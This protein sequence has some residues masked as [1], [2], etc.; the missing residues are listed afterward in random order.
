MRFGRD[1]L[2]LWP[3]DPDVTYLNHG[4][5]GVVPRRVLAAQQALRDAIERQPSRFM[6]RE[7]SGWVHAPAGSPTR[8]REAA[9]AVA[10]FIG[11]RGDDLVFVDNATAGVNA[12]L[13]SLPFSAGDEI[14]VTDLGYGAILRTAA[15]VAR[16]RGAAVRTATLP[17][18]AFDADAALAAIDAVIGPRTRVLVIDHICAET[19]VVMPVAAIVGRAHARGVPVLVD[20]AHAPGAIA[21]DVPALGADWYVANLHK[22]AH[23]PRSCGI[24]WAHPDRQAGLHPPVISWGLDEGFTREFDWMGTRDPT[25]WLTAPAGLAFLEDLG[26]EAARAWMHDL[27]WRAGRDLASRWGGTLGVT[28]AEVGAMITV[29]LPSA[30][31]ETADQAVRLRDALLFED[32]IE[33][34]LHAGHGRLWVRIS[35]QVY[36][37]WDDVERLAAAVDARRRA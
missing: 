21:L 29:P 4:T 33:I 36:N 28:E 8:M 16:E 11:A 17:W 34:Q 10:G 19:A 1:L 5:V 2:P 32:R 25:P 9:A 20:G 30:L 26:V 23:A 6:L 14:A 27:A 37:D 7:L 15:F 35:A 3:L 24:L 18:P 22:W 13:R 31:G 12:V